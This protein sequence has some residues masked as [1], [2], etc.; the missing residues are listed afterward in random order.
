MI[1]AQK[2]FAEAELQ[3]N[4]TVYTLLAKGVL[5]IVAVTLFGVFCGSLVTVACGNTSVV[6][7]VISSA[8][9][10]S[11]IAVTVLGYH[12]RR[13]RDFAPQIPAERRD[14]AVAQDVPEAADDPEGAA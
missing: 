9:V 2:L 10:L 5:W 8:Q 1:D 13:R 14:T 3:I 4:K 12:M 11:F 7:H 6:G